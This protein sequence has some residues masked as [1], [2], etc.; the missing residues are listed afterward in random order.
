MEDLSIFIYFSN[1]KNP[2]TFNET[3]IQVDALPIRLVHL[4]YSNPTLKTYTPS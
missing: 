4:L 2:T 3:Q 1:N